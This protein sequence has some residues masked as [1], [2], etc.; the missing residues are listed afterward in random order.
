[1]HTVVSTVLPLI[2]RHLKILLY[3]ELVLRDVNASILFC[4]DYTRYR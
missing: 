2:S 1:M 3:Y 4:V